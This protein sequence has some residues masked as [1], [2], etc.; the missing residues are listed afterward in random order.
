MRNSVTALLVLGIACLLPIGAWAQTSVTPGAGGDAQLARIAKLEQAVA[1]AKSSGDNAWMLTCSALVLMMT[2]PGL[3]LFYSGLVR[4]KNVLG[5]MMPRFILMATV[6][7][8]WAG[9][10]Y[11]IAFAEGTPFFGDLRYLFLHGVGATP[12]DAYA[13][14][15]PQQTYMIY[16][17]MFAI[18]TPALISGAFAERM[19][20]SA[21]LLF[22][23]LWSL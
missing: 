5:P 11:S 19:K 16:Q 13:P 22:M 15:I 7:I 23:T 17:L 21:M 2:G 4:P 9:V 18:I 14:T 12:N 8:L 6:P 1:D 3:A 10:G 20:F